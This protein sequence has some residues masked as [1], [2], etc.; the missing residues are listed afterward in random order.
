MALAQG[1][2]T[3]FWYSDN[4]TNGGSIFTNFAIELSNTQNP[5][6]VIS[7]SYGGIEFFQAA[8]TLALFNQEA[9]LLGLRGVTLVSGSGDWGVTSIPD[10]LIYCGYQAFF[11]TTSPYVVSVGGTQGETEV[12]CQGNLLGVTTSGGGFSNAFPAPSWQQ[13]FIS[14]YFSGL[15]TLPFV[16][17]SVNVDSFPS[18]Q[19]N[20]SGAGF[21]D[22]SAQAAYYP[23]IVGDTV[24]AYVAGTSLSTPVVAA[25][26]SLVNAAR[27]NNGLSTLGWLNPSLYSMASNFVN[28]ITSGNNNC[29]SCLLN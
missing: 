28:D 4:Q 6:A 10:Q 19:Y 9:M 1:S 3:T 21:P 27:V 23:V 12:V 17:S 5:P 26:I 18:P 11:P 2:P 16:N 15:S 13:P 24:F 7:M 29:K 14:S 20:R 8:S 25:M 22:I